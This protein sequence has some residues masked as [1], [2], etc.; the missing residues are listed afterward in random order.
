MGPLCGV[1][2]L[3]PC[4][5]W[6]G[7]LTLVAFSVL[8]AAG[9]GGIASFSV[10]IILIGSGLSVFWRLLRSKSIED[11]AEGAAWSSATNGLGGCFH[12][13]LLGEVWNEGPAQIS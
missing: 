11:L 5:R 12:F 13:F 9:R 6:S 2:G 1:G 8:G 7:S 3:R 10:D 4:G